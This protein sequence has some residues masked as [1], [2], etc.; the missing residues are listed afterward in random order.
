MLLYS[1]R[2]NLVKRSLGKGLCVV[3]CAWVRGKAV[4]SLVTLKRFD[5]SRK[6]RLLYYELLWCPGPCAQQGAYQTCACGTRDRKSAFHFSHFCT[7]FQRQQSL[8]TRKFL[9]FFFFFLILVLHNYFMCSSWKP[10]IYKII[11]WVE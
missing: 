8:V 3:S 4:E 6:G 5:Y 11:T 1:D 9:N 2:V 7:P 10:L